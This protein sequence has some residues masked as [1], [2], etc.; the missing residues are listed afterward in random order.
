MRV[1]IIT[2]DYP[3]YNFG[4]IGEFCKNLAEALARQGV[5]VVVITG[6]GEAGHANKD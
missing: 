2:S 6:T 4:G 1:A 3:P 5:D